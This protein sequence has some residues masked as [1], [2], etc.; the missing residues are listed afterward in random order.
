MSAKL[1]GQISS[2]FRAAVWHWSRMGCLRHAFSKRAFVRNALVKERVH[3]MCLRRCSY[4]MLPVHIPVYIFL[5]QAFPVEACMISDR[6]ISNTNQTAHWSRS[7]ATGSSR[8]AKSEQS[9]LNPVCIFLAHA[10]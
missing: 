8:D 4:G 10:R 1:A 5:I 2:T 3:I 6:S 7:E 9:L